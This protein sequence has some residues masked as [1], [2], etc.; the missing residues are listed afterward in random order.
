MSIGKKSIKI[1]PVAKHFMEKMD[2]KEIAFDVNV[3]NIK[4]PVGYVKEIEPSYKSPSDARHH[5]YYYV[6]GYHI[7][8]SRDVRIFDTLTII[9][10]G[11]W[12][13]KRLALNGAGVPI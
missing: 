10:E 8:I 9:L 11:F 13:F 2:I 6:D 12:K 1:D 7:Y 5:K 3:Y 4:A